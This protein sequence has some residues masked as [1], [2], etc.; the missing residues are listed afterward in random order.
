MQFQFSFKHMSSS[1]ALQTHA[2]EKIKERIQKF[3]SKPALAHVVFSV[4]RHQHTVHMHLS[5]GDGFGLEV[6]ASGTDMH[7]AIDLLADRLSTQLKKHKEKLK[8]H[9]QPKLSQQLD[10]GDEPASDDGLDADDIVKY[11][12]GKRRAASR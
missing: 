8:D 5:A 10:P 1:P 4:V 7:A 9:K 6:E 2:E 12:T 3:V 11:E